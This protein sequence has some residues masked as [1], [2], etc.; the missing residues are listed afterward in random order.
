MIKTF[1]M[2]EIKSF[3]TSFYLSKNE[4]KHSARIF[5]P[6]YIYLFL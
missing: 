6:Y 2:P 3:E 1:I 5:P 4:D